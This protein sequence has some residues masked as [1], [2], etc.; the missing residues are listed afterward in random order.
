MHRRDAGR[1][2]LLARTI[3]N[4][5]IYNYGDARSADR[6]C[7]FSSRSHVIAM[8][9]TLDGNGYWLVTEK[10]AI[11]NFGDAASS[12]QRSTTHVHGKVDRHRR[13]P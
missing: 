5:T 13:Y 10:G 4:G 11:Y 7:T 6:R 8:A 9:P 1:R 2:R 3:S 12:A